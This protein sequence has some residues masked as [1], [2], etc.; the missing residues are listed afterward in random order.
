MR[1]AVKLQIAGKHKQI[2]SK[3]DTNNNGWIDGKE[4]SAV[5]SKLDFNVRPSTVNSLQM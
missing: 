1:E 4:L 5:L 3:F 2:F